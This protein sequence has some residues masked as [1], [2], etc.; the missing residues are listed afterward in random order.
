MAEAG[1]TDTNG[2]GT[3]DKNGKELALLFQTSVNTVRQAEQAIIQQNLGEIGIKV[4]LK[5]IDPG[6]YFGSNEGNTDTLNKFYA[7]IQMYSNPPDSMNPA[8]TF[9][10]WLC[11]KVN[12]SANLW[13]G[14]NANRYCNSAYDAL[15]AQFTKEF[16]PDKRAAL[17]IQLNDFLVNDVATIPLINRVTPSGKAKN[18]VGPTPNT[19][20]SKLW[21]VA[22]WARQ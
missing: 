2:D 20:D 21:N 6:V 10:G 22:T 1:W 5:A 19:F 9:A 15:Y 4:E 8:Y 16:D 12:S 7:D 14:G 13:M 17:A 3:V 11:A 18:L